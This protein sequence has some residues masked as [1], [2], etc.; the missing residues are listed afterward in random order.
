MATREE[1]RRKRAEK[2]EEEK[3]NRYY[4]NEFSMPP[5]CDSCCMFRSCYNKYEDKG[6]FV[7]GRGYTQY[8][9]KFYPACG[10]RLNNGCPTRD[11]SLKDSFNLGKALEF[12]QEKFIA[13][14]GTNLKKKERDITFRFVESLFKDVIEV[15]GKRDEEVKNL[16]AEKAELIKQYKELEEEL[17]HY[18]DMTRNEL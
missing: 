16:L 11:G 9:D 12:I 8:F 7:S 15:V 3:R 2:L 13:C 1:Q 4:G 5:E 17:R 18:K 10:S 6:I 14:Q